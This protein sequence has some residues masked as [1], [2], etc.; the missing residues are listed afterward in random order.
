MSDKPKVTRTRIY[1]ASTLLALVISVPMIVVIL[2]THY[3][4]QTNVMITGIAGIV[5]LFIAM[6]FA[7]KL[8]KRLASRVQGSDGVNPETT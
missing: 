5:T 8:S 1:A 7:Y 6:G 4:L 3:V 2:V